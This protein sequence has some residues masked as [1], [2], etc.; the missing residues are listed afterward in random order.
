MNSLLRIVVGEQE[1]NADSQNVYVWVRTFLWEKGLPEQYEKDLNFFQ[2]KNV[3][4]A[5]VTKGIVGHG[6]DR[7]IQ[8]Q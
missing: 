6:K 8:T 4:W 2:K 7:A 5:T 1:Y 3:I